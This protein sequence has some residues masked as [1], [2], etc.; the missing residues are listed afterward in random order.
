[1]HAENEWQYGKLTQV[2]FELKAE[3]R[4]L[5]CYPDLFL[6]ELRW[7]GE[8]NELLYTFLMDAML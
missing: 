8:L 3:W 1:M 5:Y 7:K 6:T 4:I 2:T